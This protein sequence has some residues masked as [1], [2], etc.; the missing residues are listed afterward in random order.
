MKINTNS[1]HY[2]FYDMVGNGYETLTIC[3]YMR[4]VFGGMLLVLLMMVIAVSVLVLA[5][6][7]F[8]VGLM[9]MITG[10][11]LGGFFIP[12]TGLN[13][14]L[15]IYFI[16]GVIW[17]GA[18]AYGWSKDKWREKAYARICEDRPLGIGGLIGLKY[19]S[20]KDK[21][22]FNLERVQNDSGLGKDIEWDR[23]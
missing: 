21:T 12:Y 22:C 4:K 13:G 3:N 1:W 23:E 7:P 14:T 5:L 2:Y 9:W 6:E 10:T 15:F 16:V 17:G 11:L 8:A 20:V 18:F 19:R